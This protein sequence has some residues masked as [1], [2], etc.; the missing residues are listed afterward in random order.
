MDLNPELEAVDPH[1]YAMSL[2]PWYVNGTLDGAEAAKLG[3][4]LDGCAP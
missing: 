4:H 2:I 3:A 1:Q